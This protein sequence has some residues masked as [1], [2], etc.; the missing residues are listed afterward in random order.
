MFRLSNK[1]HVACPKQV[2]GVYLIGPMLDIYLL[3]N[4]N[5]KY[6]LQAMIACAIVYRSP[7]Y[8]TFRVL[9]TTVGPN[10]SIIDLSPSLSNMCVS[11]FTYTY[12]WTS[13]SPK[14]SCSQALGFKR[15]QMPGCFN[16]RLSFRRYFRC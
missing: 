10:V 1:I 12:P 2:L 5:M 8:S 13:T 4:P 14:T 15:P 3:A 6:A 7:S 9:W 11:L 16:L